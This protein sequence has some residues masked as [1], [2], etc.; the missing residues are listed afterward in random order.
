MTFTR[1]DLEKLRLPLIAALCL[2]ALTALL[3]RWT[4]NEAERAQRERDA[5][6]ATKGQ[7]ER[8]LRQVRTEEQDTMDRTA[9]FQQMQAQGIT[10]EEKRLDWTELLQQIQHDLRLP[11]MHYEFA[12]QK[13]LD[14]GRDTAA[15]GY[16]VSPMRLQLRLLHEEDLV[17][18]LT[19]LQREAKALV[20]IRACSLSPGQQNADGSAALVQLEADCDLRWITLRGPGGSK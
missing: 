20:L 13:A 12:P 1:R 8:R 6:A 15:Y 9:L 16:F 3:V 17:N 18:F 11:G 10:G 2:I 19:R 5:A 7:V 4:A 14:A